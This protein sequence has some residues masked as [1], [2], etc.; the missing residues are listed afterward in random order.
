MYLLYSSCLNDSTNTKDDKKSYYSHFPNL[1]LLSHLPGWFKSLLPTS[2]LIVEEKSWNAYPYTKS[3]FSCP[4]VEK[5]SL[6][7]ETY[8]TP[9]GGKME[10]VFNL[11]V[12][13]FLILYFLTF[14]YCQD[15]E[16]KNRVVELIDV[17]KNRDQ[18]YIPEEDPTIFV[19][20]KTGRGP[21][22][23]NW[24][25][26]YY[27]GCE[28]SKVDNKY[29]EYTFSIQVQPMPSIMCA[30]KLCK[31]EFRY[32]GMQSKIER[33]IHDM[34]LRNTMLRAHRQVGT[35]NTM[36]RYGI[37]YFAFLSGLGLAG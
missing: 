9:D 15:S 19:S 11:T 29:A 33:F 22:S 31:V 7:I 12:V 28:V 6:E 17:V 18:K 10:N 1:I 26:E 4:F 35:V 20:E 30:Y 13:K 14:F 23:S 3:V 24:I 8:Y 32:W 27:D 16:L 34:A 21:L 5:F 25:Q 36:Y 2:A 37:L